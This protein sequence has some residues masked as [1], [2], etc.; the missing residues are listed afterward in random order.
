MH[1]ADVIVAETNQGGEMVKATIQSARPG[2][3]YKGVHASRG[4]VTRAEPIS[5]LYE[6]GRISHV[7]AFPQLE[8]QMVLFTPNGIMGD[9]T[10]DRVDALV[11]AL[12]DLFPGIIRKDD[13]ASNWT[14]GS[15][16]P[17]ATSE[18]WLI[19]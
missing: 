5:A 18:G 7:G 1:S 16:S 6:Q 10:A 3:S 19:G 9:T 4:K 12:T 8:D 14:I 2:I 17:A 15:H 13:A 11:W